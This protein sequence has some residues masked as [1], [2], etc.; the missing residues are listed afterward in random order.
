MAV[1]VMRSRMILYNRG[2]SA[3][4][5]SDFSGG[6][7]DAIMLFYMRFC[8]FAAVRSYYMYA[9]RCTY[10]NVCSHVDAVGYRG[11]CRCAGAQVDADVYAQAE[12]MPQ[13]A[14]L[15]TLPGLRT[16]TRICNR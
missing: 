9:R 4:R 1:D 14:R 15:L 12:R 7:L 3:E 13:Y 11:E 16:Y 10:E 6:Q 8:D 2:A 5:S